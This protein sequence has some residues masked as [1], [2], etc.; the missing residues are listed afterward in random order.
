[1]KSWG[2]RVLLRVVKANQV[3]A[4]RD[5]LFKEFTGDDVELHQ[6][7]LT[8]PGGVI[9]AELR[10]LPSLGLWG[11]FS[12]KPYGKIGQWNCS[13]GIRIGTPTES[14]LTS[15]EVNLAVNPMNRSAA[16]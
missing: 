9:R 1:M 7:T 14:L 10:W 4:V 16:G 5:A 8:S 12:S 11:Q 3:R 15:I 2:R 13:F 6:R